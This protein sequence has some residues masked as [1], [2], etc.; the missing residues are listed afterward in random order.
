MVPLVMMKRS[1]LAVLLAGSL[2][3]TLAPLPAAADFSG[4][5]AASPLNEA[6]D[7]IE[8]G[9]YEAALSELQGLAAENPEDADV[10]N[11]LGYAYRKM[12][13]YDESYEHYQLALEIDPE[14]K[15]AL[16]YLGELYLQTDRLPEAEATLER[17]SDSCGFFGCE[18][19]RELKEAISAY[20]AK[21][22]S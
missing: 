10:H 14:H 6:R 22:G 17:L 7:K 4:G 12:G 16:E 21:Q 5:S 20:K 3:A 8:E 1:F 18:E 13:R 9:R 11:L 2:G 15:E 19:E